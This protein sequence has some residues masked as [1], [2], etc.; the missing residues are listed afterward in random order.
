MLTILENHNDLEQTS[1]IIMERDGIKF[2]FDMDQYDPDNLLADA[3]VSAKVTSPQFPEFKERW[4]IDLND[5]NNATSLFEDL[6]SHAQ[7]AQDYGANI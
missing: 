1:T 5:I 6:L 7:G 2:I 4:R 3:P